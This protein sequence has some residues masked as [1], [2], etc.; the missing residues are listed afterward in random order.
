MWAYQIITLYPLN[1]YNVIG[2]LY[3]IKAGKKYCWD[4]QE[5]LNVN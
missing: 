3:P 4:N 2:Q 1:L 5:N